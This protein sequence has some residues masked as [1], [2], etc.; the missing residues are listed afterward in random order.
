MLKR[1][2]ICL[3]LAWTDLRAAPARTVPLIAILIASV[4]AF[5]GIRAAS[6]AFESALVN[7][8]R[9]ALA[10]DLAIEPY[11]NP[12]PDLLTFL[13]QLGA[14]GVQRSI[15]VYTAS[16]I[17]SNEA[18]DPSVAVVKAVDP[19]VYPFYGS[20]LV[21]PPQTLAHALSDHSAVVSAVLLRELDTRVGGVIRVGDIDCRISA[22]IAKEPDRFTGTFA[23]ATRLVISTDTLDRSG[24]LRSGSPSLNRIVLR[25]PEKMNHAAIR[26]RLEEMFPGAGV[27]APPE[28][29][30]SANDAARTATEF[31]EIAAWLAFALGAAG[32]I[33][34]ARLHIESRFDDLAIV[35]SIG[36]RPRDVGLWLL[37]QLATMGAVGGV[38][39]GVL[40]ITAERALLWMSGIPSRPLSVPFA[41][42]LLAGIALPIITGL[43]AVIAT[44][45]LRPA[46]ILRRA[47]RSIPSHRLPI[48]AMWALFG[49]AS[50]TLETAI[51]IWI[52]GALLAVFT[53]LAGFALRAVGYLNRRP[54]PVSSRR[55]MANL[56]RPGL[57]SP[58][59]AAIFAWMAMMA[60]AA[61]SGE[62][63]VTM[64][65]LRNLPVP[66]ANLFVMAVQDAQLDGVRGLLDHHP[67]IERPFQIANL[68]WLHIIGGVASAKL[69]SGPRLFMVNCVAGQPP[70]VILDSR[71]A[72]DFGARVGQRL[73]FEAGGRRIQATV[74]GIRD[75]PPADRIWFSIQFPCTSLQG[76]PIF[77]DLGLRVDPSDLPSV[78]RDLRVNYPALTVVSPEDALA[79][80]HDVSGKAVGLVRFI[81]IL[82]LLCGAYLA[83]L[84]IAVAARERSPMLAVYQALGARPAWIARMLASEFAALGS[85]GALIGSVT[86]LVVMESTLTVI[87][88]KSSFAP[89]PL[90]VAAAV[91][92]GSIL[93]ATAG[94]LASFRRLSRSP[95]M[96]LRAYWTGNQ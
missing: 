84:L 61:V 74:S 14:S 48:A 67:G 44:A 76:Q 54:L 2:K 1:A 4:A 85:I 83:A 87:F 34:A 23:A 60:V 63:I 75:L 59:V 50:G 39:G 91:A 51:A 33:I 49:A 16:A 90:I 43:V 92:L 64:E 78:I 47:V 12:T 82:V 3:R 28:A 40:G 7:E 32:M 13:D 95:M 9:A 52:L 15:V 10:G 56:G 57:G 58:A 62:Q 35:K 89:H 41:Q 26:S 27:F 46:P 65:I 21:D 96:T 80:V 71:I 68:S 42:G 70:G 38:A 73:E 37:F 69:A 19:D 24:L 30:P 25:I 88:R 18:A 53:N 31:L 93:S 36:A 5:T 79:Q 11:E 94:V 81:A 72:D 77:H 17:R 8:Q 6:G 45:R 22:V 20:L 86:G 66:G 55:G 29:T